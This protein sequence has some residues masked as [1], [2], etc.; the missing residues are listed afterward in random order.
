MPK[1]LRLN[2]VIPRQ[3]T[4]IPV[5]AAPARPAIATR[6]GPMAQA[7][8]QPSSLAAIARSITVAARN[9]AVEASPRPAAPEGAQQGFRLSDLNP[10]PNR[11][12]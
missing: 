9:E 2:E 6:T 10:L 11:R 7:G 4:P 8:H 3:T 5:E 12:R 1:G